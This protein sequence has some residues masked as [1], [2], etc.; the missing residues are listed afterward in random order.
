MLLTQTYRSALT[1]HS[2][3]CLV[4]FAYSAYVSQPHNVLFHNGS[5]L[6][7]GYYSLKTR[8]GPLVR[9]ICK[10]IIT[11]KTATRYYVGQTTR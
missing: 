10:L 8:V 1:K 7:T 9:L 2:T 6:G 5:V 4:L 11:N 3:N